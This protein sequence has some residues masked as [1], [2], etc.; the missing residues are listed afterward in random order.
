MK[1]IRQQIDKTYEFYYPTVEIPAGRFTRKIKSSLPCL[2]IDNWGDYLILKT[3][4]FPNGRIE[5]TTPAGTTYVAF[6]GWVCYS[7]IVA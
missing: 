3:L 1:T 4:A 7:E 6:R 5:F 2:S